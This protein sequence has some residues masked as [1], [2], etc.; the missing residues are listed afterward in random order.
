VPA[1]YEAEASA[2]TQSGTRVI[3]CSGCSGSRKVGDVG[4]N[5]GTLQ[6]NGITASG[7]GTATVT[8]SYVN[9]DTRARTADLSVNGGAATKVTF[10]VTRDWSTP[11]TLTVTVTLKSGGNTLKFGNTSGPAPDFDKIAVGGVGAKPLGVAV[12]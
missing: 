10:P 11:G 7:A 9:G 8:I 5:A 12:V 4:R 2:N 1:A 6:F 3:G